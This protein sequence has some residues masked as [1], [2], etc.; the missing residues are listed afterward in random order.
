MLS[1]PD[2]FTRTITE[3]FGAEGRAWLEHLPEHIAACCRRWKLEVLPPF[4]LSYNY[5]A[6]ATSLDGSRYVLKLGVPGVELKREIAALTFYDG[7]GMVRLLG[8]DAGVGALLLERL[9]PGTSLWNIEDDEVATRVAATLMKRLWRPV[10]EGHAFLPLAHW[11]A[12]LTR[13]RE[14]FGGSTGPLPELLVDRA[15]GFFKDLLDVTPPVLLHGDLHHGNILSASRQPYLAIDP[16]GV[17]GAAGY[18][19]GPFLCNPSPDIAHRPD[20]KGVLSRRVAIFGEMLTMDAREVAAW[21]VAHAVLSAWWSVED[22]GGG[23]EAALRCATLLN[24]LTR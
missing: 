8:A 6:P 24:D 7:Q 22:H 16:K 23:W 10:P 12:G 3:V 4:D 18:E 19:V 21:G 11:A 9:E 14:R 17:V 5:V 20:L 13:L 15:E 1:L 2:T